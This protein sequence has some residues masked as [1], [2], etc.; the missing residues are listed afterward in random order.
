MGILRINREEYVVTKTDNE[1]EVYT[2]WPYKGYCT[3]IGWRYSTPIKWCKHLSGVYKEY[4]PSNYVYRL[5]MKGYGMYDSVGD[6]EQQLIQLAD[7]KSVGDLVRRCGVWWLC[8]KLDGIRVVWLGESGHFYTRLGN[9]LYT[10]KLLTV[11]ENEMP[12]GMDIEGE[13]HFMDTKRTYLDVLNFRN[14]GMYNPGLENDKI[15]LTV[16]DMKSDLDRDM[17]YKDRYL[18][19]KRWYDGLST[20]VRKRLRLIEYKRGVTEEVVREYKSKGFEGVVARNPNS[21]YVFGRSLKVAVKY[22]FKKEGEYIARVLAVKNSGSS[23]VVENVVTKARRVVSVK[24]HDIGGFVC[25]D[26]V[27]VG[28]GD[29]VESKKIKVE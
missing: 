2:V 26:V 1:K 29:I 14:S 23:L 16:Y 15:C 28:V 17:K 9:P 12:R 21:G 3:C 27:D 13:L 6:M 10:V 7:V 24:D 22:K 5:R 11:L 8:E 25:G 18:V 4:F 19:M 20:K